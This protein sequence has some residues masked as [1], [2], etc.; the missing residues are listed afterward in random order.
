MRAAVFPSPGGPCGCSRSSITPRREDGGSRSTCSPCVTAQASDLL[1]CQQAGRCASS[2]ANSR[3]CRVK[4]LIQTNNFPLLTSGKLSRSRPWRALARS[5]MDGLQSG[6]G[7][8]SRTVW[9]EYSAYVAV[10]GCSRSVVVTS[11]RYSPR[12]NVVGLLRARK[13]SYRATI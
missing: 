8:N 5:Y 2:L 4:V 13:G 6:G 10:R 7:V 9:C 12:T 1:T 11:D 3:L